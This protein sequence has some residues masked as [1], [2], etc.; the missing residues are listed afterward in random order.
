KFN[1]KLLL[2]IDDIVGSLDFNCLAIS[3]LTTQYRHIGTGVS[4][5]IST[6]DVSQIPREIRSMCN[7]SIVFQQ[8]GMTAYVETWKSFGQRDGFNNYKEFKAFI[9][10]H[11]PRFHVLIVNMCPTG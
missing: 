7:Y 1:K 10:R 6:Q 9:E 8:N 2:I 3:E 4:I 11:A 5:L